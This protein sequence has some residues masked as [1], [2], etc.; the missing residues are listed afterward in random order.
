MPDRI[1]AAHRLDQV[2]RE[3]QP[4]DDGVSTVEVWT[5]VFHI[6]GPDAPTVAVEVARRVGLLREEVKDVLDKMRGTPVR[7]ERYE[8][9]FSQVSAA[10][11]VTQLG[12]TWAQQKQYLHTGV[13]EAVGWCADTLPAEEETIAPDDLAAFQSHVQNF[14]NRIDES[15]LP[16]YVKRFVQDQVRIIERAIL[17]YPVVGAKAFKRGSVESFVNVAENRETFLEQQDEPEMQTL[18]KF[19]DQM[20][21]FAEKAGPWIAIGQA[22][23]RMLGLPGE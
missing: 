15:P 20:Q 3:A 6:T 18:R 8:N 4:F 17:D 21:T 23:A 13:L 1:N 10:L 12:M 7:A 11:D 2:L 19:W 5:Q 14:G 16:D 22:A 9:A